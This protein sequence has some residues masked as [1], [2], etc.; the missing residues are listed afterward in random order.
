[1]EIL[2]KKKSDRFRQNLVE[3]VVII[4]TEFQDFVARIISNNL[5]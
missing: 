4:K 2:L 5:T 1:M 3:K